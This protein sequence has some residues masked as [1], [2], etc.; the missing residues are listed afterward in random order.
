MNY[1]LYGCQCSVC[2]PPA[3]P[4]PAP[5]LFPPPPVPGE[6]QVFASYDAEREPEEVAQGLKLRAVF[7]KPN[8]LFLDFDTQ[9]QWED[10]SRKAEIVMRSLPS[11]V[12]TVAW[13]KSGEPHRHVT[14]TIGRDVSPL[15]RVA[16][17]AILGS[18]PI[19]EA[20][21]YVRIRKGDRPGK[22]SCFFEP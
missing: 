3:F 21:T 2:A 1:P 20:L 16:L 4:P 6:R 22:E 8:E 13:S 11:F 19:R 18:D 7:P 14:C 10:F 5:P 15:E 12:Y 9:K 17:Q